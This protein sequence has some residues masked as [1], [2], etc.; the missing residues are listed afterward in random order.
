M[1]YVT[2]LPVTPDPVAGAVEVPSSL[3][4]V[5]S[6]VPSPEGPP[7]RSTIL[8]ASIQALNEESSAE[9]IEAAV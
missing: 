2:A 3:A 5:L 1:E 9:T 6:R 4:S 7:L 8:L